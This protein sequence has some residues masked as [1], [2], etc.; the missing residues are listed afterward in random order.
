MSAVSAAPDTAGG[1]PPA[2][3][4]ASGSSPARGL[5]WLARAEF[6]LLR[7][8][9]WLIFG[10]RRNWAGLAVLAAVPIILAIAIKV[11]PPTGPRGTEGG[12]DYFAS[13]TG[14]GIF[15]AIAALGLEIPLFLPLAVSAIAADSIAGEASL[16]T[17]RYLLAVPVARTRVLVVKY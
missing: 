11:S 2:G 12:P 1:P 17:L 13:I 3:G 5:A 16:G 4:P 7:S 10:R 14:N 8:E 9:L 6:R 15:V